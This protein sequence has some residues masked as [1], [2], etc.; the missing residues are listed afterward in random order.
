MRI[1][2]TSLF[3]WLVSGIIILVALFNA[4]TDLGKGLAQGDLVRLAG[5]V[6]SNDLFPAVFVVVGAL[7]VSRQP[8]NMIGWLLMLPTI[9]TV[10]QAP[11]TIE[12]QSVTTPVLSPSLPLWLAV[13][14]SGTSWILFIF[15]VLLIALLFPTGKPPSPRWRWVVVYA[16]GM[17]AFFL[18]FA[19]FAEKFQLDSST[20]YSGQLSFA[21]PIG[22]ISDETLGIVFGPWWS[23]ALGLV[24]LLCVASLFVRYRRAPAA[25]KEQIKWLLYACA[26]FAAVYVPLDVTQGNLTGLAS[27][28]L[29]LFFTLAVVGIPISIGIAILRYRLYDIDIIIR[30]TLV[31]GVLTAALALFYLGS[32]VVLQELF[33]LLTGQSSEIAIIVSTLAIAA[34]FVPLRRR[35]QDW[36]DRRF[37]RRKYDA[38]KVLATF[39]A[40]VRDEVELN[41]LTSELLS[42][43][44]ETMQ[45]THSSLWVK[46]SAD[47]RGMAER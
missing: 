18:F 4:V 41:K 11:I 17:C 47:G 40:T 33:R 21:N 27:D 15:P 46:N 44:A 13:W 1:G 7:I 2:R 29:N 30:R 34:L 45:P 38:A 37:Y 3:A 5:V 31:Y 42:V 12:L 43:V 28:V 10:L 16:L 36:I 24:T 25:V 6:A 23:M 20:A 19:T 26:L 9:S 35:V 39:G 22:F 14:F 8:R 32:V